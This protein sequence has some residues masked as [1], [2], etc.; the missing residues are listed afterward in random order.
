MARNSWPNGVKQRYLNR[1]G[2]PVDVKGTILKS[3][4][5]TAC[6]RGEGIDY[7]RDADEVLQRAQAHANECSAVG[8]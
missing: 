1:A 5:C 7:N 4:R 8:R 3:W 2:A 6:S